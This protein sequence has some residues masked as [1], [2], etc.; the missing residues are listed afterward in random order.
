MLQILKK[1]VWLMVVLAAADRAAAFT[2]YGPLEAWQTIILDYGTRYYYGNDIELGGPKNFDEGSRL[3]VPIITYAYD[4]TFLKF[5]GA[6]GVAAVDSAMN[7]LN[8]LPA[9]SQ[10]KLS[11]FP[12][13]GNQVINYT[14]QALSLTDIKTT[15]MSLMIEHM[16]LLGESHVWDLRLR[17]P[18]PVT[19]EYGY[20]VILRNYDPATYNPSPYVNG[21]Q[22][23][24][25]IWDG[26]SNGIQTADAIETTVDLT[27]VGQYAY[28]AVATRY[29]Q[30][31]GGYYLGL[32]RDDIGGLAYLYSHNN[33]AYESLDSNSIA[34]VSA[35]PWNPVNP[36]VTNSAT[37]GGFQGIFGGVEKIT[38]VKVAYD[39]LLGTAFTPLTYNYTIPYVTNNRLQ[40][41]RVTRTVTQPDIIFAAGDLTVVPFAVTPDNYPNPYIRTYGFL[42]NPVVTVGVDPVL[43]GVIAPQE[44]I[45]FNDVTGVYFNENPSFLDSEQFILYPTLQWGSFNGSTNAPIVFPNSASIA[46]LEQQV[47]AGGATVPLGIWNPVSNTNLTNGSTGVTTP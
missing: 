41:L 15:V 6:K 2:I 4:Y 37:N 20:D 19:C 1:V 43:T 10:V 36:F 31:V 40:T 27:S 33:Y 23:G 14:A 32:T 5:F 21:V 9:A 34:Q 22:V 25:S 18:T 12:T 44:I 46:I 24:Y 7:E 38:Y 39:S 17:S 16:G 42:T 13:Q 26:C 8:N 11:K 3:N 45:T 35:S 30:K 29:G 47:L 28:S